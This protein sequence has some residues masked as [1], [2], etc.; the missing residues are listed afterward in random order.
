MSGATEI[1]QGADHPSAGPARQT[2]TGHGRLPVPARG[3]AQCT[4][5]VEAPGPPHHGGDRG[6]VRCEG[7]AAVLVEPRTVTR[8]GVHHML[9]Q[10]LPGT[11]VLSVAAPEDV[12]L[13]QLTTSATTILLSSGA[14]TGAV[15][16][17]DPLLARACTHLVLLARALDRRRLVAAARLPID[18][19]LREEDLS[20]PSMADTLGALG[21]GT[22]AVS[23]GTLRELLFLV[24]EPGDDQAPP[25]PALSA[26]ESDTLRL[27][28]V[29]LSNREI[30]RRMRITE[31]GVKR[32]VA[33]VLAKLGCQNRTMAVALAMRLG[34]V[35]PEPRVRD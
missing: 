2:R 4:L 32:H 25:R 1:G 10:A 15:H 27:M 33:N 17:L 31:H 5:V 16:L 6:H 13:D 35:E 3:R 22:V 9:Q 21:R 19:I 26:R 30:A 24:T 7:V 12:P 28:S 11:A 34:L 23:R 29:G 20:V 14:L 8:M 18:A